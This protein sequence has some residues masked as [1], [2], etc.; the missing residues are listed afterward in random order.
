M[1]QGYLLKERL[2]LIA[3]LM[4][5]L[6]VRVYKGGDH[7]TG[8]DEADRVLY[9]LQLFRGSLFSIDP[10]YNP[11]G[12]LVIYSY[13]WIHMVLFSIVIGLASLLRL[14]LNEL[15]F[16]LPNVI[17]G[18]A[19]VY[20]LYLL[21]KRL[22]NVR[23]GLLAALLLAINPLHVAWSRDTNEGAI[24]LFLFMLIIY[25]FSRYFSNP[26][27]QK[28]WF[29]STCFGM[30]LVQD[31]RAYFLIP[32][33]PALG[34]C[35]YYATEKRTDTV[36][37]KQMLKDVFGKLLRKEIVLMPLLFIGFYLLLHA[38]F[39]LAGHPEKGFFGRILV[40][41]M[42]RYPVWGFHGLAFVR[43]LWP[44]N[45]PG[46]AL[47]APL[48]LLYGMYRSPANPRTAFVVLWAL[49]LALPFL[50]VL[51]PS[52]PGME[53]E[54]LQTFVPIIILT[55][56]FL[57]ESVRRITAP[58]RSRLA[59]V[60][61]RVVPMTIGVFIV[62]TTFLGMYLMV[63]SV[64]I[65][66]WRLRPVLSSAHP[67]YGIKSAGVYL[68]E[69]ADR[70]AR[71]YSEEELT[72]M[73]FYANRISSNWNYKD[74]DFLLV[75]KISLRYRERRYPPSEYLR[76]NYFHVA[77]IRSQGKGVLDIFAKEKLPFEVLDVETCDR[78]FDRKYANLHELVS[79]PFCSTQ[80]AQN[81]LHF[82]KMDEVYQKWITAVK[83]DVKAQETIR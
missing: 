70:Y 61:I 66:G 16:S 44:N 38:G 11:V 72:N 25:A 41:D 15:V 48:V 50:F 37:K 8:G 46:L 2:L 39:V 27:P 49:F 29:A 1:K 18:V 54:M 56:V 57:E 4:G 7:F 73:M 55:A 63:Y 83:E 79:A 43:A 51:D 9:A 36:S 59:R 76:D 69:R 53:T 40:K 28:G 26:S 77:E 13:S 52:T 74:R 33:I 24:S 71:I 82:E 80:I 23:S 78:L 58:R 10:L 30:Y 67:N 68:R 14:P 20:L 17:E 45:G 60:L 42:N 34:I 6:F 65:K 19:S 22:S 3:I 81:R 47:F 5:A 12:R 62:V 35:E 31:V 75:P 32:L 64:E 21:V